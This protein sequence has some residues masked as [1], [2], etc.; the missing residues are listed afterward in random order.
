MVYIRD[1]AERFISTLDYSDATRVQYRRG[2][3]SLSRYE[4]EFRLPIYMFTKEQ[5]VNVFTK[6][7]KSD[8][9]RDR[10]VRVLKLYFAWLKKIG[11]DPS[12]GVASLKNIGKSL[13]SD[14]ESQFNIYSINNLLAKLRHDVAIASSNEGRSPADYRMI[15]SAILL[16]WYGIPF[17]DLFSVKKEHIL[18]ERGVVIY[19]GRKLTINLDAYDILRECAT[20]SDYNSRKLYGVM[21]VLYYDSEYLFRTS[22]RPLMSRGVLSS[23]ISNFNKSIQPSAPYKNERIRWCGI[24]WRA[25]EFESQRNPPIFK[26]DEEKFKYYYSLFANPDIVVESL[27]DKIKDYEKFIAIFEE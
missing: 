8:Q 12:V 14:K 13:D 26:N 6:I 25:Y 27:K 16:Q 7:S 21:R 22:E 24:Y 23:Y 1:T 17:D 18:R 4:N 11:I 15:K 10:Y 5:M 20:A 19:N 9:V 3:V 2:I